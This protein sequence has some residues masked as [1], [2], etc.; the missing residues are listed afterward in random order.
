MARGISDWGGNLAAFILV[1]IVNALSNA[2]PLNGQSMAEISAKFPSLF[3]PAGFTFA[4][5]GLIYLSLSV[6]VIY[7]ALPAQ[8]DSPTI[9][10]IGP[11]FKIN[12]LANGAW[13]VAWHY[14]FL[15]LSLLLMAAI[16]VTLVGIYR[17]L[18]IVNKRA[19]LVDRLALQLPF[20]LY[21]GWISVATIAN[22]SA[23][24]TGMGWDNW[25]IDAVTWTQ[26]KI[27]L[28]GAVGAMVLLRRNDIV[29]MLVIVWAAYGICAK[30][31]ATPA[32]AGAAMTLSLLGLTLIALNLVS[33]SRPEIKQV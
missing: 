10:K 3:T 25:L 26:L 22:I 30:Q 17:S 12:C 15:L 14:D 21:T 13:I 19:S 23:V 31:V 24:Q 28:A 27:A 11:L 32:V 18:E 6:F 20:S 7:Q 8:R 1:I 29:F 4:I 5:W 2:I 33:G 9:A 16:L